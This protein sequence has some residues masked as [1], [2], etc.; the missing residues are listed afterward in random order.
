MKEQGWTAGSLTSELS[1][2]LRAA[3]CGG[4]S[5]SSLGTRCCGSALPS[6][7]ARGCICAAAASSR[8]SAP[9][10]LHDC[11]S[12]RACSHLCMCFAAA[13]RSV[14][15]AVPLEQRRRDGCGCRGGSWASLPPPSRARCQFRSSPASGGSGGSGDPQA[16]HI[17]RDDAEEHLLP[18]DGDASVSV[19]RGQLQP[20][21]DDLDAE[22]WSRSGRP[23]RART[24]PPPACGSDAPPAVYLTRLQP[25]RPGG[26]TPSHC[27]WRRSRTAV[28]RCL[29]RPCTSWP[30]SMMA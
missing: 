1:R 20:L 4:R 25:C 18:C 5:L 7:G 13:A 27:P 16:V 15:C 11:R 6:R 19:R 29:R 9:P 10:L 3:V 12:L 28:G 24:A 17:P 26:W 23:V 21:E 22:P 14:T 2:Q 8:T 30:H